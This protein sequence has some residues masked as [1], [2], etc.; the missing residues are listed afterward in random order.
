MADEVLKTYGDPAIKN[1]LDRKIKKR[2]W[3]TRNKLRQRSR[4]RR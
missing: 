2:I 1:S 4:P 3:K